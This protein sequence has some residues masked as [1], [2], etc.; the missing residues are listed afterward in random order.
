[1]KTPEI[2]PIIPF[3]PKYAKDFVQLNIEWLEKYFV[4][5]PHDSDL[6]ERCEETIIDQGGYIFFAKVAEEIAG[7]FALIKIDQ[8]TYELGKM[9]VLP[10]FRGQHIGQ[11]L[12]TYSLEFAKKQQWSKL[13]LY[14]NTIL[15]NAIHIYRK[16]GFKEVKLE[17]NTPYERSNIKMEY[18]IKN[19]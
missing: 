7:T 16:H 12:L 10:K 17:Q 3:E 6:L 18:V 11:Q 4:V 8:S 13:I 15:K 14:S 2:I 1:M 9:A 5:E 19:S